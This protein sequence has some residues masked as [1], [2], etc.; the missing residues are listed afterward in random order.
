MDLAS[1]QFACGV[2]AV[3]GVVLWLISG[4]F[5]D[6]AIKSPSNFEREV[7]NWIHGY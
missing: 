2:G 6:F 3:D 4:L 1:D 7:A 5:D